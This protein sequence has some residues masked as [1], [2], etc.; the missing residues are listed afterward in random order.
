FPFSAGKIEPS[1]PQKLVRDGATLKLTLPVASQRV[2]EF[3]RV[4]G[5][6]TASKSGGEQSAATIDVP[7]AGS[8]VAGA[9]APNVAAASLA[10]GEAGGDL[11]LGVALFFA[12]AG[13]L[14]LNLMPCVF[15]VLSLK[16][17]GFATHGFS[18]SA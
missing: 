10:S 7:L 17:L 14:L 12:F 13:G 16:V 5:V 11:S 8:V 9:A 15:P 3:T 18:G 6:L 4:A 2:G 1:A